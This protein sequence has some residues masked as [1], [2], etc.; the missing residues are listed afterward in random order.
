[1]KKY[2]VIIGIDVSKNKLD[3][4][5]LLDPN[6]KQLSFLVVTND[7]KGI[8]K[9]LSAL[10][11]LG[12]DIKDTL[13]CFENT[14]IYS[15]SLAC[16]LEGL[17]TDYWELPAIEIKR[18]K[19]ISRGKSDKTDARDIAFYA[20]THMHKLKLSQ[21]PEKDILKLKLLVSERGKLLKAIQ[22]FEMTNEIKGFIH[23]DISREVLSVNR[24]TLNSLRK[25]LL[26]VEQK[27]QAII[28]DNQE[29]SKQKELIQSVTGVGPQTAIYLIITTKC[30][31][32]FSNWRKMAC[33]A[34]VAPFP[35][36]SGSS[37]KG[38][39]KVNHMADKKLKSLLTMC[40]LCAKKHD[41]EIAFYYQRKVKEGKNPM[42]VMNSIKCKVLS[43]V[44]ATINRGTPY[45]NTCKF[46]A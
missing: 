35:Y 33:Y 1:M 39:T 3:V 17:K 45:V 20:H 29:I 31:K 25:H 13:F 7:S 30:F 36:Q 42:L 27:I 23:N 9:I 12:I 34:G 15:L 4:C 26:E 5:L 19:G 6:S 32:S 44:F 8:R 28:K 38:R 11:K 24:K 14:G 2:R 46:A 43:R 37:I 21:L 22:I 10:K 41:K 16:Y 40:A 18:S